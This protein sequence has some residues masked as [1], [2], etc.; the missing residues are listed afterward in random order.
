MN[1]LQNLIDKLNEAMKEV[2]NLQMQ[3]TVH[4]C[5]TVVKTYNALQAAAQIGL[6]IAAP[7]P[8]QPDAAPA[9]KMA[10]KI[11][12]ME[13]AARNGQTRENGSKA[14]DPETPENVIRLEPEK[15]YKPSEDALDGNTP[16]VQEGDI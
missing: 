6:E 16:C 8:K 9:A 11:G 15:E 7:A 13:H 2:Q 14:E 3:P 4:N 1:T 12:E 5:Q 10:Q